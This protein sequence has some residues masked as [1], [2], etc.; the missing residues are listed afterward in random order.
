MGGFR[1]DPACSAHAMATGER[2]LAISD[3]HVGDKHKELRGGPA[4]SDILALLIHMM[5]HCDR[6]LINGDAI[7]QLSPQNPH[8]LTEDTVGFLSALCAAGE[9]KQ[10]HVELVFGNHEYSTGGQIPESTDIYAISETFLRDIKTVQDAYPGQ[11]AIHP[12]AYRF[13][14][15]RESVLAWHGELPMRGAAL[16]RL[17]ERPLATSRQWREEG[18]YDGVQKKRD[19]RHAAQL[20]AMMQADDSAALLDALP[21]T[22]LHPAL[23]PVTRINYGHTHEPFINVPT[24]PQ[25]PLRRPQNEQEK[26]ALAARLKLVYDNPGTLQQP[27][28]CYP[29]CY[30]MEENG[31][32]SARQYK[33]GIAQDGPYFEAVPSGKEASQPQRMSR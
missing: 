3:L 6:L 26:A 5:D 33:A 2:I 9:R 16:K 23:G 27:E 21:A 29:I 13:G 10:C 4:D 1:F 32:V 24:A 25:S 31:T 18:K 11:L 28:L 15:E 19:F 30:R 20:V 7:E 8:T 14:G 17:S 22:A 12:V